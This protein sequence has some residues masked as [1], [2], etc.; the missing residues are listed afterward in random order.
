MILRVANVHRP[1][2]KVHTSFKR[3]DL[4]YGC[5]G[6]DDIA[7]GIAFLASDDAKMINGV[8]MPSLGYGML[9]VVNKVG[10]CDPK[11]DSE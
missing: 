8:L 1:V 5:V 9:V 10:G 2:Q 11:S 6:P 3:D 7:R 4:L